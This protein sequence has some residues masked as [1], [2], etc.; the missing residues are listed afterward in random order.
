MINQKLKKWDILIWDY[1]TIKIHLYKHS[2]RKVFDFFSLFLHLYQV[3]PD[4]RYQRQI[5]LFLQEHC[6]FLKISSRKDLIEYMS[7]LRNHIND[8]FPKLNYNLQSKQIELKKTIT[9]KKITA[10]N[11]LVWGRKTWLL[12]HLISMN[13]KINNER[14]QVAFYKIIDSMPCAICRNHSKLYIKNHPLQRDTP[15]DCYMFRFH[16]HVNER[17]GKKL[18]KNFQIAIKKLDAEFE[19]I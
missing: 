7:R 5:Q 1:L 6:H 15:L 16:N 4:C 18:I 19:K 8:S 2:F 12:L 17:L 13:K 14:K 10:K 3:V 11:P 9:T